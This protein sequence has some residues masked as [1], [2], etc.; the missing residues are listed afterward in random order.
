MSAG[1]SES[2]ASTIHAEWRGIALEIT[3]TTEYFAGMDHIAI[4]SGDSVPL[5]MT[6]T[7][8]RSHFHRSEDLAPYDDALGFV[9]AW[10][11]A[12]SETDAWK[13]HEAERKQ[14]SLF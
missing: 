13:R 7:G 14:L 8:Y 2:S 12:V 5:P 3:Y 4:R 1:R 11:D 6:E 9:L 10:L